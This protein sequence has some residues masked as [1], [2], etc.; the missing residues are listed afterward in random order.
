VPR[1]GER[2]LMF[3]APDGR[4]TITYTP[5][6]ADGKVRTAATVDIAGGTTA[7][8]KV[9]GEV[10]GSPLVGY[11]VSAAGDVAYGAVL[12]EQ[13]GRSDIASIPVTPGAAGQEQLPV[14]LGY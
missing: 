2:F 8:V 9:P 3:G 1:T 14:V 5:I 6:T 12:L 11:L 10:G 4:A 7:S 13:G